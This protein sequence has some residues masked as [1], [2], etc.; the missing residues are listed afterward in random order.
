MTSASTIQ[1]LPLLR[2]MH[3]IRA[4]GDNIFCSQMSQVMLQATL[5]TLNRQ[6]HASLVVHCFLSSEQR[7]SLQPLGGKPERAMMEN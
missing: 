7:S 3:K 5:L 2:F 1:I 6:D 4:S